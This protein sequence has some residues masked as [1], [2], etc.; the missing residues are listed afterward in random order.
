MS[1]TCSKLVLNSNGPCALEP[2]AGGFR[3]RGMLAMQDADS[4]DLIVD[5]S[6][7]SFVPERLQ[8]WHLMTEVIN[9]LGKL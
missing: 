2:A 1:D 5:L 4:E 9:K 3:H 8:S 7:G 6:T